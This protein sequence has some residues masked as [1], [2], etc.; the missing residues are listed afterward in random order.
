MPQPN[1]NN[2]LEFCGTFKSSTGSFGF[3]PSVS[4]QDTTRENRSPDGASRLTLIIAPASRGAGRYEARIDGDD[5]V[6]CISRAPF[7]DA[8]RAL[9]AA[10]HDADAI[11]EMCRPGASSWD[12][13]APLQIAAQLDVA[14][15]PFGPK[16]IRHRRPIEGCVDCNRST[17]RAFSGSEFM[18]E[19][20]G[21]ATHEDDLP[22][23]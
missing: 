16:F 20:V 2:N 3:L 8:A 11:L 19:P 21:A 7:F 1:E 15:T 5:R 4:H 10:G 23:A 22:Q 12:L 6:L 13:R 17:A 14:E 9:I 18:R